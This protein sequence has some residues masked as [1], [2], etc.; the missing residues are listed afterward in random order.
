[1]RMED[2]AQR[3]NAMLGGRCAIVRSVKGEGG[4]PR[5]DASHLCDR[6]SHGGWRMNHPYL[7]QGD[8]LPAVGV[9]QKLLNRAGALLQADGIFGLRTKGSRS[10]RGA[11][12]CRISRASAPRSVGL[13]QAL[14]GA[15]GAAATAQR[16]SIRAKRLQRVD[17]AGPG[18]GYP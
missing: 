3:L 10:P 1:M 6:P 13:L 11:G 12:V 8:R 5:V 18:R 17:L 9:L 14:S 7:R 16:Q 2:A 15:T 4:G